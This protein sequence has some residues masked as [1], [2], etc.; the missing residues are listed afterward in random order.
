MKKTCYIVGA[1]DITNTTIKIPEDAFVIS[2]DGGYEYL[3]NIG[4]IPDVAVGDFDSLG[5]KPNDTETIVFPSEKDYPDMMLA[6]QEAVSR[7]FDNI[8][9][10]GALGGRLDHTMGN[11]QLLAF[12]SQRKITVQLLDDSVAVTSVTD[13][14][15]NLGKREKGVV[16]VFAFGGTAYGVTIKGL[17]YTLV[18]ANM[19]PAVPLGVS[20]EFIGEDASISVEKGNLIIIYERENIVV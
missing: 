13:S 5:Y 2:A 16:S 12:F 8:V 7:G 10:Y 18:N 11:L 6:A 19:D 4:I 3:K 14:S 20:N 17:K 15:I 1:G 9:I